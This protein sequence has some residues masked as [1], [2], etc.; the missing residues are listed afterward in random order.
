MK[1]KSS[2]AP[3]RDTSTVTSLSR[4]CI[5]FT[6]SQAAPENRSSISICG[7]P[8]SENCHI[9]SVVRIIAQEI[10]ESLLSN[11]RAPTKYQTPTDRRKKRIE[12]VAMILSPA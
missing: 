1:P 10:R 11:R 6:V 12:N 2:P 3:K 8:E 9:M 4:L 7:S 5:A